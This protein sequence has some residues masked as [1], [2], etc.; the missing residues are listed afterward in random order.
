LVIGHVAAGCDVISP[1][2][3]EKPYTQ[4]LT[5]FTVASQLM[6]RAIRSTSVSYSHARHTQAETACR[7]S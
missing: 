6:R 5:G 7:A 1:A 3:V 2:L 4:R